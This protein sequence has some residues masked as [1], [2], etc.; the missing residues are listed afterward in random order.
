MEADV[1]KRRLRLILQGKSFREGEVPI[2]VLAA[3][4]QALQAL[5]YHAT[6]TVAADRSARRGLWQNRY[7]EVAELSFVA[8]HHSD[9]TIEVEMP[10]PGFLI[11][12]ADIGPKA[13]D[14]VFDVGSVLQADPAALN[15]LKLG[16]DDR[17]YL[18]RAFEGVLPGPLDDYRVEIENYDSDRHPKLSF[19][20]ETRRAVRALLQR[21]T[22]PVS[23]E[24]VT[25]VGELVKI[26]VSVGP[27]KIAIRQR[28]V[29]IDCYYPDSLRDQVANLLAGS[30]V[31]VTGWA[32]LD[33]EGR[34][35][36]IDTVLDVEPVSMDP[37]RLTR[38]EHAGQ[39]YDLR[40]PIVVTVEYVDGLWVY[41]N[42]SLNLWGYAER[43]EDALRDLH[44]NFAYLWKELAEEDDDVLDERAKAIKRALLDAIATD[45]APSGA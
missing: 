8:A 13:L 11:P 7:R 15:R 18:L 6:A 21:E 30:Y 25:I 37:I 16:K 23:A 41:H 38:F 12:D 4:L 34:V 40:K 2:S 44:E 35:N 1:Q 36:R 29:E 14:L 32:T 43:R 24:E 10:I 45:T 42:E 27:E 5:L 28:G 3:K 20:G 9:L 19:S 33:H 39:R 26:H 17:D 22:V 31:E